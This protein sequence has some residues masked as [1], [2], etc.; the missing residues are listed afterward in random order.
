[1]E[2]MRRAREGLTEQLFEELRLDSSA[3]A[4]GADDETLR[5]VCDSAQQGD[6]EESP[7][8]SQAQRASN[9]KHWAAYCSFLKLRS[10]WRPDVAELDATGHKREA[11]I[12]AAALGWIHA[13]MKPRKGKYLPPGPPHYGKPKP[14]SPL[15][16][17]AVL[18]GVRAEHV[19]RGINPPSLTLASKRAHE[20]MLRY[21][22]EVGRENVVPE[23]VIPMTHHLICALLAIP[24]ELPILSGGKEWR[25]TTIPGR[26]IRTLIHVLAQ[27]GF[28]KSEV[29]LGRGEWDP[30]R[31]SFA[32][33][34]WL[35]DGNVVLHPTREQ[36]MSLV[37]GRDFAILMPGPSKADVFG[38]RWGNNPIWLPYDPASAINAAYALMQWELC[39]QVAPDD[40][41]TTPLFCG[42]EGIGTPLRAAALDTLLH[43]LLSYVLGDAAEAK[44][45]SVHSFRSYL[46]S[47]MMA[48]GCTDGQIQAALRWASDEALQVYKVVQRED[49]GDWITR[50]GTAK[51]TGARASSLKEATKQAVHVDSDISPEALAMAASFATTYGSWITL[52]EAAKLTAGHTAAL[53]AK[54]R[55]APTTGP[56]D[57]VTTICEARA[58]IA[59]RAERADGADLDLIRAF[60]VD[61]VVADNEES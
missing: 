47:A 61:G 45:Y 33:L 41:R 51:L 35:I 1:M 36:L 49:Y 13:R 25:W 39:T 48:A 26:G 18:R 42:P 43:R 6:P 23:R 20:R 32:S 30:T 17:L 12:W 2:A 11:A 44:K 38:M 52:A 54:G 57:L 55:H 56:E 34:K 8:N 3:H 24:N 59:R 60:G 31:M 46:C 53:A 27:T 19:A 4:I 5:W 50:A 7:L 22:R 28:R 9:W 10:P 14:P 40:R 37:P 58:D 16:A 21:V 29:A 15:S